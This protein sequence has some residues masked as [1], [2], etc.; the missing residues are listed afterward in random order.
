MKKILP[1]AAALLL[2]GC[3][4]YSSKVENVDVKR[5]DNEIV[6]TGSTFTGDVSG[7]LFGFSGQANGHSSNDMIK[8]PYNIDVNVTRTFEPAGAAP[9]RQTEHRQYQ[10]DLYFQR[11]EVINMARGNALP[12]TIL[13][14]T[15][16][17][18]SGTN[19]K[20][21]RVQYGHR[22]VEVTN[23]GNFELDCY[24]DRDQLTFNNISYNWRP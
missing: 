24:E 21:M 4:W 23:P 3:N 17:P 12:F 16:T 2:S 19:R 14:Q 15:T 1:L 13:T 22:D 18:Y 10:V 5:I 7:D 20:C 6:M 8:V 11:S 9:I